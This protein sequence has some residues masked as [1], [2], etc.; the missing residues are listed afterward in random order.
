MIRYT[1]LED[2]TIAISLCG[3]SFDTSLSIIKVTGVDFNDPSNEQTVDVGC[4]DDANREGCSTES[5]IAFKAE[6]DV[7]YYFVVDGLYQSA[8]GSTFRINVEKVL[9][10][11]TG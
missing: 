5:E 3:S 7:V 11:P 1:S 9:G 10:V 8:V 2:A 4:N 6:E